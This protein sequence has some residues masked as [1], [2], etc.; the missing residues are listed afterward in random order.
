MS[1]G[2]AQRRVQKGTAANRM[3]SSQ[4]QRP[5]M[6]EHAENCRGE[7]RPS[8]GPQSTSSDGDFSVHLTS[9]LSRERAS[10]YLRFRAGTTTCAALETIAITFLPDAMKRGC[11]VTGRE[12]PAEAT[13]NCNIQHRRSIARFVFHAPCAAT[14]IS[15][16]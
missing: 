7:I 16:P 12:T 9:D 6:Q 5:Q 13:G 2:G 15:M 11:K 4:R 1:S 10:R 3:L 14:N 8:I